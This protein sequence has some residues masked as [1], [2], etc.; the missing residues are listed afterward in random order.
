MDV[1]ASGLVLI[2]QLIDSY[3]FEPLNT[4][5]FEKFS[6]TPPLGLRIVPLFEDS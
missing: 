6:L 5:L 3:V 2:I 1:F 4:K